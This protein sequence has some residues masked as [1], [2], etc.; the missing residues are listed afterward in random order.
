MLFAIPQIVNG[1][2][3]V[4]GVPATPLAAQL[5][6]GSTAAWLV[7]IL[8]LALCGSLL[9]LLTNPS[10]TRRARPMRRAPDAGRMHGRGAPLR[11]P[12]AFRG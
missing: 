8:T 9:L 5:P 3:I 7:I 12:G 2:P 4:I 6:I 11:H 10:P 1:P